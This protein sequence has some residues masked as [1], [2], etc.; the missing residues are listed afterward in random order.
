MATRFSFRNGGNTY[1]I[2]NWSNETHQQLN[3]YFTNVHYKSAIYFDEKKG[4]KSDFS[5]LFV[6]YKRFWTA[7]KLKFFIAKNVCVTLCRTPWIS[8]VIWMSPK[9]P[10]VNFTIT[11]K[12][13]LCQNSFT[14]KI[15][16]PN[17][18]LFILDVV[19]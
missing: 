2:N 8:G 6:N 11:Y 4:C 1:S 16:K 19:A 7:L 15:T 12:Q 3:F 5:A 17:F 9:R 14:K 13:L 10:D 18:S